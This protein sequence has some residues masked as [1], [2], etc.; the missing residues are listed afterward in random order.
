MT[1]G[2]TQ[3][4]RLDTL[5]RLELESTIGFE[6][7]FISYRDNWNISIIERIGFKF[8][9]SSTW[10]QAASRSYSHGLSIRM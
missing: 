7:I 1:T 4:E 2:N 8:R 3:P 9:Q 5:Q 6:G 10:S